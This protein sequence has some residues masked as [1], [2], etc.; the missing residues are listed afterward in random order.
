M[1]GLFIHIIIVAVSTLVV[2]PITVAL[3]TIPITTVLSVTTV[4]SITTVLSVTTVLSIAIRGRAVIPISASLSAWRGTSQIFRFLLGRWVYLSP[5]CSPMP[6][7]WQQCG[8]PQQHRWLWLWLGLQWWSWLARWQRW[9]RQS[10]WQQYHPYLS[11]ARICYQWRRFCL[12]SQRWCFTFQGV[13]I[14]WSWGGIGQGVLPGVG[15]CSPISG[16][17]SG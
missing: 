6:W 12:G 8:S 16:A 5:W 7:G 15:S 13:C 11:L 4:F 17:P 9:R 14:T 1:L 2:T 10:R 3:R